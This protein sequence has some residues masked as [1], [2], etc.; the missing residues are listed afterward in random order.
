MH[1]HQNLDQGLKKYI[2]PPPWRI[3]S[4][5]KVYIE[6]VLYR[7][8]TSRNLLIGVHISLLL[9]SSLQ[10]KAKNLGFWTSSYWENFASAFDQRGKLLQGLDLNGPKYWDITDNPCIWTILKTPGVHCSTR[11]VAFIKH[12]IFSFFQSISWFLSTGKGGR[13]RAAAAID[14]EKRPSRV[15]EQSTLVIPH[16]ISSSSSSPSSSSSHR[17]SIFIIFNERGNRPVKQ[18]TKTGNH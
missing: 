16:S 4:T 9:R 3:A 15:D 2:P 14:E 5:S 17:L 13:R 1:K 8:F 7:S 6:T 12:L 10:K 18:R 11:H